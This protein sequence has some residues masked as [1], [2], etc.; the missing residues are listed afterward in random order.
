[1]KIYLFNPETRAYLGEDFA[2][3]APMKRG[4]FVMPHDATTIAPP[5]VGSGQVP[6]FSVAEN[7]WEI[8]QIFS[9]DAGSSGDPS[10]QANLLSKRQA[11][12]HTY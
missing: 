5:A 9:P 1:M 12:R 10:L 11:F 2:D 3:E 8:R 4:D 6:A 7:Q